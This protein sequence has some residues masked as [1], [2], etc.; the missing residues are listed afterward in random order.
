MS[1]KATEYTPS[2]YLKH[3][4]QKHFG[5]VNFSNLFNRNTFDADIANRWV[6]KFSF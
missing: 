3:L 1:T 6:L 5:K 4:D 2:H